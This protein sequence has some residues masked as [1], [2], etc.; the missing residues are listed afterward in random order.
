V[1]ENNSNKLASLQCGRHNIPPLPAATQSG[2]VT[3]TFNLLTLKL[4]WNVSR[5]MDNRSGQFW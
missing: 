4:V 3:L 5:G 2:L 1:Q